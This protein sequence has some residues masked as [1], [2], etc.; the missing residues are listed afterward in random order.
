MLPGIV[1]AE[2]R[3]PVVNDEGDVPEIERLDEPLYVAVV[4]GECVIDVRLTGLAETD[5]VGRDGP[6]L[7]F[8]M[9]HDVAPQIG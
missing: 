4:I 3:A 9:G 7:T 8:D 2:A 6:A 1:Q 5:V